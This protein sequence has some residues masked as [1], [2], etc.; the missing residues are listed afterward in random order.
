MNPRFLGIVDTCALLS[1]IRN[2]VEHGPQ[3]RSRLLR[4]TDA[5]T[6]LLYASDH[7]YAEVYRRLPKIAQTSS[8]SVEALRQHFER[9]YLPV[10]HFVTVEGGASDDPQV[11]AITDPDDVPTGEL[12]KLIAPCVVFSEDRHLR[13]PGLAPSRWREVARAGVDLQEAESKR[14]A[15]SRVVALPLIGMMGLVKVA[16]RRIEV[17]PWL[18]GGS[19][20]AATTLFLR[21]PPRRKR[22]GQYATT[23]FEA[24]AAEYEQATQ[25]EQRSLRAIR[26]VMLSPPAE[27]SLKQQIAIVLARER[28]PLLARE[29]HELAQQHFQDPLALSLSEVRA[30]LANGPEFVQS[31]RNRWSFGRQAAPWQGVL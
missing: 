8:A 15:T 2:D 24:L 28:Q 29:I 22:V 6:A 30:A 18:L 9:A 26:L 12:A 21:K 1:S 19:L 25:L 13:K 17:S 20:L 11:L 7:V 3:W 14:D 16:A 27:P 4:M 10:L 5:G 23:F 31:E